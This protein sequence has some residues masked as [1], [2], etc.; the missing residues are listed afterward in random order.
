MTCA[1]AQTAGYPTLCGRLVPFDTGPM[2]RT[3]G[4]VMGDGAR[5]DDIEEEPGIIVQASQLCPGAHAKWT[6][7]DVDHHRPLL[8]HHCR[9]P[10]AIGQ[11]GPPLY[12]TMHHREPPRAACTAQC[13][14]KTDNTGHLRPLPE[15]TGLYR[16]SS[17][18]VYT[19]SRY[20]AVQPFTPDDRPINISLPPLF[21][22]L[23]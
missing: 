22:H 3:S 20:L 11:H 21:V 23:R 17:L 10:S 12:C 19:P 9:P 7:D 18:P 8:G 16:K 15:I 5:L 4:R 1:K 14:T 6:V 2:L 13:T